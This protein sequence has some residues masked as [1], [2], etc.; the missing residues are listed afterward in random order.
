MNVARN[1]ERQVSIYLRN[2]FIE[3]NSKFLFNF[4]APG[5]IIESMLCA[6]QAAKD[7]C[8]GDSGDKLYSKFK[9][10]TYKI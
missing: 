6:G 3:K 5:G 4:L 7:S 9:T 1:M 8:S 2:S 10:K